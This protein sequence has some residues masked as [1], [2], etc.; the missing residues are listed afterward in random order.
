MGHAKMEETARML[1]MIITAA[2]SL[3]TPGRIVVLVRRKTLL[4]NEYV[5]QNF[6]GKYPKYLLTI[7]EQVHKFS[8]ARGNFE[9]R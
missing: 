4:L 7:N 6:H 9:N 1:W 3:D 8:T 5:Q 2:V